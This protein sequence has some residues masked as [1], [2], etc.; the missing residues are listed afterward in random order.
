MSIWWKQTA[1]A[2]LAIAA[3]TGCTNQT[4]GKPGPEGTP[5]TSTLKPKST[6]DGSFSL[7]DDTVTC[8]FP[9]V[10]QLKINGSTPGPSGNIINVSREIDHT[11]I[12]WNGETTHVLI[13]NDKRWVYLNGQNGVTLLYEKDWGP[14]KKLVLCAREYS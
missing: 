1:A 2:C 7:S 11:R 3:L 13:V 10:I 4:E 12:E 6:Q 14:I 8:K 5:V 9:S